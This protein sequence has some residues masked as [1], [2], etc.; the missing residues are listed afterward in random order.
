MEGRGGALWRS[1]VAG[2]AL[3]VGMA[4]AC[5]DVLAVPLDRPALM[6]ARAVGGALLGLTRAGARLVAVGEHGIVLLSDDGGASWGQAAVPTS[7]TLTA[8]FFVSPERGWAVGHSG[9]V[10]ATTDGGERWTRQLDGKAAAQL[11][12]KAAQALPPDARGTADALKNAQRLVGDGADKPFL[13]LHF[14]DARHGFIIGAYGLIFGTA[15]GGNTWAP[16]LDRVDNPK[17]LHLN[18]LTVRANTIVIAGEQGLLLRSADGGRTFGRLASPYEGSWF[19]A[20]FLQGG[21]LLIAG[22]RGNAFVSDDQGTSFV[23]SDV[24]LPVTI[25]ALSVLRDGSVLALN[26]AGQAQISRDQG[27]S[28]RPLV[29]SPGPPL[30]QITQLAGG[31]LLA[32]S[33]RG[34]RVIPSL[35]ASK[36]SP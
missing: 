34:V 29:V 32:S 19:A 5:A 28:L 27:K 18:A 15:D 12:L 10:L 36:T 14:F 33:M 30:T 31:G 9:V 25:S 7:V 11:A 16:W 3:V 1:W 4:P 35:P 26:Q 2:S 13:D 17:G 22:L 24:T 23:K 20:S 21:R 8:V 6:T